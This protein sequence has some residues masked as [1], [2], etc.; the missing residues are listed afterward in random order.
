MSDSEG[1]SDEPCNPISPTYVQDLTLQNTHPH[2]HIRNVYGKTV[3][4][5]RPKTTQFTTRAPKHRI[6]QQRMKKYRSWKRF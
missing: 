2:T 1:I 3:C 4:T 6:S 5:E